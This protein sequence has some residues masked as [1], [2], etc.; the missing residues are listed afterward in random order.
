MANIKNQEQ[1]QERMIEKINA[2]SDYWATIEKEV[3]EKIN[4]FMTTSRRRY[5]RYKDANKILAL[6]ILGDI[7]EIAALA[8]E[9]AYTAEIIYELVKYPYKLDIMQNLIKEEKYQEAIANIIIISDSIKRNE[10]ALKKP[11]APEPLSQLRPQLNFGLP[12]HCNIKTSEPNYEDWI[13]KDLCTDVEAAC[14]MNG[15]DPKFVSYSSFNHDLIFPSGY[16]YV[17]KT[18]NIIESW[19]GLEFMSNRGLLIKYINKYLLE[20]KTVPAKLL[21]LAKAKFMRLYKNGDTKGWNEIAP[22][23]QELIATVSNNISLSIDTLSHPIKPIQVNSEKSI[24]SLEQ[25]YVFCKN[26]DSWYIKFQKLEITIRDMVGLQYIGK[27][28]HLPNKQFNANLLVE[29]IRKPPPEHVESMPDSNTINQHIGNEQGDQCGSYPIDGQF[30]LENID[31]KARSQYK[32]QINNLDSEISE[33]EQTGNTEDV[34]NLKSQR[35]R[36]VKQIAKDTGINGKIRRSSSYEN[37]RKSVKKAIATAIKAIK[38]YC[39]KHK[40][41]NAL[42]NSLTEHLKENISTGNVCSYRAKDK[43][44]WK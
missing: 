22:Q 35:E 2:L 8:N 15:L 1:S 33:A 12:Y 21:K 14:L 19:S 38:K 4:A 10:D 11:R 36:I 30:P 43:I 44:I 40:L 18:L 42:S 17:K 6:I 27:L 39:S 26:G 31:E 13:A 16:E 34:E 23:F 25:D 28:L 9:V 3:L 7:K 24:N 32:K 37:D 29:L 20:N 5:S 41:S